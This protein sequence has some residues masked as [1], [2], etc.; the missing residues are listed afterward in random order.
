MVESLH[1]KI[2]ELQRRAYGHRDEQYLGLKIV[3]ALL[4]PKSDS[5]GLL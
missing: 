4:L 2:R 5:G 3:A 1:N